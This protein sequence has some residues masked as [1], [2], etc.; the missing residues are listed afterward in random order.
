M[1]AMAPYMAEPWFRL[2]RDACGQLGSAEMARRLGVSGPLISQVLNASGLYGSGAASTARLAERVM[3]TLGSYECPHLCEQY[4]ASRVISAA[5]CR[6]YA[7]RP[8]PTGS[9]LDL[10]HWQSCQACGHRALSAPPQPREIKPRKPRDGGR[11]RVV[12]IHPAPT[13]EITA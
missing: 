11:A 13:Q 2:L 10:A 7:H 8:P 6:A 9:P 4:G 3:H 12:D 1:T 5:Q